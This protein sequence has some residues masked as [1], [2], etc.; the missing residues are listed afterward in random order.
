MKKY[1]KVVLASCITVA[2]LSLSAEVLAVGGGA[3]INVGNTPIDSMDFTYHACTSISGPNN[4]LLEEHGYFWISSYQDADSV[5]DSWINY[6]LNNGY[7]IYGKYTYRATQVGGVQPSI[8]G[9]RLNYRVSQDNAQIKLFI[10]PSKDTNLA[11][12]DCQVIT[13]D[14]NDDDI[15]LGSSTSVTQGE[16]SETNGLANGDFK[17]VFDQ[18]VWSAVALDVLNTDGFPYNLGDLNFLVF[19]GNLT[20]LGGPLGQSHRPEGSGNLF[21]LENFDPVN[22]DD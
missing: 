1:T 5:V 9:N 14:N 13:N 22:P 6:A 19:N 15:S 7:H 4:N 8:S 17:V 16:K 2:Q 11:I 21:W 18:W 3:V 12:Q 10:D 20:R